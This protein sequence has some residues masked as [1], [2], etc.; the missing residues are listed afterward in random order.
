MKTVVVKINCQQH[1][2]YDINTPGRRE[3]APKT[4]RAQILMASTIALDRRP[5]LDQRL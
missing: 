1:E 3:K 4:K 2:H 5:T